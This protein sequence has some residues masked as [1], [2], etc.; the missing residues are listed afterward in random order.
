MDWLYLSF[1]SKYM[2]TLSLPPG[3][4]YREPPAIS[5]QASDPWADFNQPANA[6]KT[7]GF[8]SSSD[9]SDIQDKLVE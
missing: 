9:R 5:L 6:K 8:Y 3:G 7:S 2:F 1:F 4:V